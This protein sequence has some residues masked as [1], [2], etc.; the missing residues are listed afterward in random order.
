MKIPA[1]SGL[2]VDVK[3]IA[4]ALT[5]LA[6]VAQELVEQQSLEKKE[7]KQVD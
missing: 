5:K 1:L 4:D 2:A 6:E 7:D 3:K